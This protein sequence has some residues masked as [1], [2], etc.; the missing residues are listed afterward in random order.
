[1]IGT[2]FFERKEVKDVLAYLRA[3]LNPKS[4]IDILRIINTP[5]RGIGKVTVDKIIAEKT[6][7]LPNATQKKVSDFFALLTKIRT[8]ISDKKPSLAIKTIISESGIG[9]FYAHGDDDDKERLL[10]IQ[11]LVTLAGRYDE[12]EQEEG[13]QQFL[14]DVSLQSDQDQ[15]KDSTKA[16]RLMT[17][18]A[19]K[20]LEF[21]YVFI[22]GL[23]QDLFPSRRAHEEG[24]DLSEREEERRL[25]YVAITRAAKKVHLSLASFRTIFGQRMVNI[26]SEF[27]SDIDDDLIDIESRENGSVKFLQKTKRPFG[28]HSGG[29]LLPDI[30]EIWNDD[31]TVTYL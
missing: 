23:E 12:F 2:R 31:E 15:I 9:N 28:G 26:P 20:G 21:P 27:I 8:S 24:K 29:G 5:T 22:T 6:D 7:T 14:S 16:V 13:I 1:V 30:D 10:N 11:E 17:V 18:H 25:F 19:A 4:T 3:A